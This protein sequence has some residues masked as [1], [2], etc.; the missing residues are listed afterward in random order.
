MNKV[1]HLKKRPDFLRIAK[2]GRKVVKSGFILQ[3]LPR[4]ESPSENCGDFIRIGYTAS[5][6]VG[7]AVCRNRAK[8]RLRALC[9]SLLSLEGEP[10]CDYV[11]IA[12]YKTASCS[13]E[14]LHNDLNDALRQIKNDEE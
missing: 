5:K 14:K 12:R 8:R 2:T 7:N 9:S 1:I 3:A 10:G 11:I 6:K 4:K 13:Y